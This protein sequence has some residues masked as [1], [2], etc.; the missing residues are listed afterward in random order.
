MKM[1]S[2]L[3]MSAKRITAN[4]KEYLFGFILLQSIRWFIALPIVLFLFYT[5]LEMA[6]LSSITNTNLVQLL[7][8]PLALVCLLIL[9][10]LLTFF[11]FY[12]FGYYFLLAKY[13]RSN[14]KFTFR[15]I[16]R[17]LNAKL[18][19][20]FS[21]HFLLF[22]VY[23]AIM[24]PIASLGLNTSWT[25]SLQIPKFIT[26]E[27]ENTTMGAIIVLVSLLLVLYVN[28]RFIFTLLYFATDKEAS[29]RKSLKLSWQ[30]T[31]GKVIKIVVSL[32]L[33]VVSFSL[34]ITCTTLIS[35]APLF[36]AEHY[37]HIQLP[38][39]AGI[40]FT[41]IQGVAFVLSALLQPMLTEALTIIERG[42]QQQVVST[43][44]GMTLTQYAKKYRW[45]LAAGFIIFAFIHTS[46]LKETVYQ[47][48][49]K[50]V[51]H[52]GYAAVALENTVASLEAAHKAGA[53]MVEMDIQETKD[54][55]FVVYHDKTLR[56]LGG[57]SDII[58]KMTLAEL[59]QVTLTSGKFKEPLPTFEDYIDRAKELDMKLLVETKI[60]GHESPEMEANLIKLLQEKDV[61]YDYVVQSLDPKHLKKMKELDPLIAT[62][63]IIAL[64]IGEIPDTTADFLSLEDFSVTKS[65]KQRADEADKKIFVWTVNQEDL[66]HHYMRLDVYG[67]ITNYVT[68]AVKVRDSYEEDQG[69]LQRV[70][71]LI[72]EN[73]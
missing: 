21:L 44:Q 42:D 46:T 30:N 18:P 62:S 54:K 43:Y 53:E 28:V 36:I 32:L 17:D 67:L 60:Y 51:A 40:S 34:I 57:S 69:L 68:E 20:F 50:I 56:R 59:E 63:E 12:E 6:G 2:V 15:T 71:F 55:K 37:A 52:R 13:Q 24:L 72:E 38:I 66:M 70:Q 31:K 7:S 27:L 73:L 58:G 16:I 11:I 33:I 25:A 4:P 26:D 64:N 61:A 5:M 65:L 48:L 10:F 14:E 19:K 23:M 45:L 22:T 9:L 35:L 47:P 1:F 29:L 49:T 8:S 41:L 3:Q 39:L